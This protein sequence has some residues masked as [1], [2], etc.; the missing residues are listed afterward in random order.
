MEMDT[1]KNGAGDSLK[2]EGIDGVVGEDFIA[3]V[4]FFEGNCDR[5]A[6]GVFLEHIFGKIIV[7]FDTIA[8]VRGF[9]DNCNH[10]KSEKSD[11]NYAANSIKEAD[12]PFISC[13]ISFRSFCFEKQSTFYL[14]VFHDHIEIFLLPVYHLQQFVQHHNWH[15]PEHPQV[16][17][18]EMKRIHDESVQPD[19]LNPVPLVLHI[20]H[21]DPGGNNK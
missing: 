20:H 15:I 21:K 2:A 3:S 8:L 5:R 11:N 10:D 6:I 4:N 13:S 12:K 16:Q 7:I 9:R 19:V 14:G 18:K 17:N 1:S